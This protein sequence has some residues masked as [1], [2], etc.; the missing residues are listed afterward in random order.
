VVSLSATDVG[1][2]L[3]TRCGGL[4][5]GCVGI[6]PGRP[7]LGYAPTRSGP[8]GPDLGCMGHDY[9][10]YLVGLGDDVWLCGDGGHHIAHMSMLCLLFPT[11]VED[12]NLLRR[13]SMA[14]CGAG[15]CLSALKNKG[16][17]PRVPLTS[18]RRLLDAHPPRS[19]RSVEF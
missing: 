14:D 12:L 2:G 17:G 10:T 11:A 5:R 9:C 3:A 6:Q 18:I 1:D 8:R 13:R 15:A 16:G 19:S 4:D 7:G